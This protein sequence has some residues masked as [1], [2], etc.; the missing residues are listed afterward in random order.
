MFRLRLNLFGGRIVGTTKTMGKDR[1]DLWWK[2]EKLILL[3]NFSKRYARTIDRFRY[4]EVFLV[5][6]SG[7]LILCESS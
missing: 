4:I 6:V 7:K 2:C 5:G 3:N 1:E